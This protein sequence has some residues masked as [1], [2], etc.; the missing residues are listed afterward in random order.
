MARNWLGET[1][2]TAFNRRLNAVEIHIQDLEG[3]YSELENN[4]LLLSERIRNAEHGTANDESES[5]DSMVGTTD[6]H[7]ETQ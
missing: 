5:H 4:Y 2:R 3:R 7:N 6:G 1:T